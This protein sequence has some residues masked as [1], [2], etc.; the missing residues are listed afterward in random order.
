[1]F[2]R[3]RNMLPARRFLAGLCAL[4]PFLAACSAPSWDAPYAEYLQRL[5]RV[6]DSPFATPATALPERMPRP[7]DLRL[8]F[9][10]DRLD[11]LDFLALHGCELQ[12]TIGKRNSSLGRMARD[13]QRLLLELEF[14]Q[15]APGCIARLQDEGRAELALTLQQAW[16]D[17]QRE[18]PRRIFKATL[19]SGEYREFWQ[20]VA[21]AGDYPANTSSVPLQALGQVNSLVDRWLGGDYRFDN[22]DFEIL[23]GEVAR[24]DGGRLWYALATQ[25]AWLDTANT[26][27]EGRLGKGP[28][29]SENFRDDAADILPR[30]ISRYFVDGTQARAADLGRRYHELLPLL[31]ELEQMLAP[32]LPAAY[33]DWKSARDAALERLAAAPRSHVRQLQDLLA[34][35]GPPAD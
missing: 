24:G 7:A 3:I 19:G 6:L 27:I 26:A 8:E 2:P 32:A 30:V 1:M 33:R 16:D 29:C 14:L 15:L 9:A 5:S 4:L 21:P 25:D 34:P 13:S 35:C 23:L 17:K 31:D 22:R 10:S 18:L 12:L 11:G 20:P 28:L